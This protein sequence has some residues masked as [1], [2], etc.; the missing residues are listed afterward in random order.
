M[1][2][3]AA[4]RALRARRIGPWHHCVL[5]RRRDYGDRPR[6]GE[7]FGLDLQ[8]YQE[9]ESA[10]L[11]DHVRYVVVGAVLIVSAISGFVFFER[12][13]NWLDDRRWTKERDA[14]DLARYREEEAEQAERGR[15]EL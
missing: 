11:E 14:R 9:P 13:S 7:P 3:R 10:G 6:L 15:T 12:W 4:T 1:D 2:G 8:G 5:V